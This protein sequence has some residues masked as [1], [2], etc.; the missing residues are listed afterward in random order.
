MS[1]TF[2]PFPSADSHVTGSTCTKRNTTHAVTTQYYVFMFD[3]LIRQLCSCEEAI[4]RF[5]EGKEPIYLSINKRHF[6]KQ[7]LML[8][9]V[10]HSS[11]RAYSTETKCCVACNFS[12]CLDVFSHYYYYSFGTS[13]LFRVQHSLK[14]ALL[15][16]KFTGFH[17]EAD[18]A[19][20]PQRSPQCRPT[21]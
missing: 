8:G 9:R 16:Y 18:R 14:H 1:H 7:A 3:T 21:P 5:R 13:S 2:C 6:S 15:V 19:C 4:P 17:P 10:N 12:H 11:R 20:A